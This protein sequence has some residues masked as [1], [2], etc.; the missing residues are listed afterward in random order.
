MLTNPW[1][2]CLGTILSLFVYWAI[3]KSQPL[4]RQRALVA[5]S[6]TLVG[7]YSPG[8][9]LACGFL[10]LIP[11]CAQA[12]YRRYHRP[13]LF[14]LFIGLTI[15]PLVGLRLTTDQ[16]FII[17]FGVA[18]ATVKSIA[19]VFTAYGKRQRIR[20][21]DAALL[22]FF[23]PLFTVGPVERL[24]TFNINRLAVRFQ[25]RFAIDGAYRISLGLFLILFVCDEILG[26]WRSNWLGNDLT[27]IQQFSRW[28]ALGLI[29]VS[30]LYTYL[31]FEGFSS[32]AIGI[33]RLFGLVIIENFDRPLLV[34]NIADFWKRYHISMG[35][36]ISQ[37]LYFPLVVWLKRPYA[38][39][40]ATFTS[41]VLFGLWHSFT[42]NYIAWGIAN[43]LGVALI[44]GGVALGVFPILKNFRV[45]RPTVC[46]L[47]GAIT[48]LY[49]AWAQ[50]IANLESVEAA[51]AL[52]AKLILG[53]L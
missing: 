36:W 28:Q 1:L 2:L 23:F 31:N 49:V 41:F 6:A 18:F 21:S 26:P 46:I 3:P 25:L 43:G 45:A 44:H 53:R 16:P 20:F 5:A 10:L 48:L 12:I 8:G 40:V 22:I 39:Y 7:M 52:T 51:M 13:W 47:G 50:T 14:W 11:L 19:L 29:V 15:A 37:H 38:P 34:S 4:V 35:N 17:S 42:W 33:S 24:A 32:L 30:F 9:F 27:S